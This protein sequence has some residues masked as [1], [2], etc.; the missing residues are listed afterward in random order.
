MCDVLLIFV[1]SDKLEVRYRLDSSKG[2]EILASKAR[3]LAN[4]QLHTV[5]IS[6]LADAVS[7]QVTYKHTH[8]RLQCSTQSVSKPESAWCSR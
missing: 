5:T 8:E 4:G 1:C 7:V 2:A 3:G 6:R